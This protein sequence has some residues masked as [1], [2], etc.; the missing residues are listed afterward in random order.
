MNDIIR[1]V[2]NVGNFRVLVE[3][4]KESSQYTVFP[5]ILYFNREYVFVDMKTKKYCACDYVRTCKTDDIINNNMKY[6]SDIQVYEGKE[7]LG[8]IKQ[9]E[10]K[11]GS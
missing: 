8:A 2:E 11:D 4:I 9:K 3:K 5:K 1:N 7:L 10:N 6:V